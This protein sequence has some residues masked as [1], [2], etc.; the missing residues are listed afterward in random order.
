M[1][2][3]TKQFMAHSRAT[4][5]LILSSVTAN[6]D[7]EMKIDSYTHFACPAF[8]DHLEAESKRPMVFRG[9]FSA[10]PELSNIDLR[11][12]LVHLAMRPVHVFPPAAL[13]YCIGVH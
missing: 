2:V 4:C 8:M 10:I 1:G 5:S 12:R 11:I 9:L 13:M 3:G 6:V 7:R